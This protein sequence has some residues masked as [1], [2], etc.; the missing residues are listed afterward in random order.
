[1]KHLKIQ[2]KPIENLIGRIKTLRQKSDK[3]IRISAHEA[4]RLA[5]SLS[6]VMIRLVTIQEEIIEALKT[7]QQA[8]TVSM[9]MDGGTFGDKK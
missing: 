8:Q 1:M 3:E 4:A 9:E 7:A 5:D 6:Q 2:T